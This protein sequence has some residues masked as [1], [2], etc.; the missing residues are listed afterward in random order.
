MTRT[1]FT[2][3]TE[4]IDA[5]NNLADD[6]EYRRDE[7]VAFALRQFLERSDLLDRLHVI[8]FTGSKAVEIALSKRA[9][10]LAERA[11]HSK[12]TEEVILYLSKKDDQDG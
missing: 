1:Y 9:K 12:I 2:I 5:I 3:D 11:M 6:R 4:I 8:V 7:V 10:A